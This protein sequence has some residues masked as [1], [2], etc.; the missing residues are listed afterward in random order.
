M[1]VRYEGGALGA[2]VGPDSPGA[3]VPGSP[4]AG[5]PASEG[6]EPSIRAG[7]EGGGSVGLGLGLG[8]VEGLG[9]QKNRPA[10]LQLSPSDTALNKAV[11]GIQGG[12][13]MDEEDKAA[14]SEVSRV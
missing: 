11:V 2:V 5:R 14:M 4:L 1:S 8:F 13:P 9:K 10:Q 3:G 12:I 6:A 7:S